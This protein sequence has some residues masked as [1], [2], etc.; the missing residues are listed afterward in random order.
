LGLVTVLD[1]P[2]EAA[3]GILVEAVAAC[4]AGAHHRTAVELLKLA[5]PVLDR[6]ARGLLG[7]EKSRAVNR[8]LGGS[9]SFS[10]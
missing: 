10:W 1:A 2:W 3:R 4:L 9:R 5:L 7:D 8:G 6:V